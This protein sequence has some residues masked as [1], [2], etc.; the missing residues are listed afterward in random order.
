MQ[1]LQEF[2]GAG[3]EALGDK[4]PYIAG[5]A[6][7][8]RQVPMA[9]T[10]SADRRDHNFRIPGILELKTRSIILPGRTKPVVS[11]GI[12][13]DFGDRFIHAES[14]T[15]TY[16]DK[17]IKHTW[18]L[19]GRQANQADFTLSGERVAKGGIG[20]ACWSAHAALGSKGKYQEELIGHPRE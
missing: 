12:F 4:A 19:T 3:A 11:E 6:E 8:L 20:W 1:A 17:Q 14:L 13:D 15:H 7:G 2:L 10:I 9:Y 16:E 5:K 18:D